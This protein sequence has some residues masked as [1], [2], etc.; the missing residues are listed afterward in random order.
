MKKYAPEQCVY[1]DESGIDDNETYVYAWGPKGQRV[2]DMKRGSRSQRLTIIAALNQGKIIAPFVFEGTCN[3]EVMEAYLVEQLVPVLCAGQVVVCDNASFHKG[4]KIK[5]IIEDVGCIL[6]YLPHIPPISIPSKNVGI[7]QK[8]QCESIY[9]NLMGIFL[10]RL[11]KH[12]KTGN[13]K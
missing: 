1:L 10:G 11:S 9:R 8:T 2:Y 3:R 5:Q 13:Y 7:Q 6:V 12:L 4:G